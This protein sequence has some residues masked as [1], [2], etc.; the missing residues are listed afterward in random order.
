M[1]GWKKSGSVVVA[2]VRCN[3]LDTAGRACAVQHEFGAIKLKA[4]GQADCSGSLRAF[5]TDDP[6][7]AVA[8][9]MCMPVAV[10]AHHLETPGAITAG[11]PA[12]N[13]L[14]DQPVEG[15]VK[16]DAV[17]RD[18]DCRKPCAQ[19]LVREWF[20][21]FLQG[22]DNRNPRTRDSAAVTGDQVARCVFRSRLVL[23]AC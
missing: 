20:S 18:V 21:A 16:G 4:G 2:S 22:F 10:R 5:K 23:S 7:T 11:N 6:T 9:K 19:F 12:C 13:T 8:M 17:V 14:L 15:A 3:A 1:D